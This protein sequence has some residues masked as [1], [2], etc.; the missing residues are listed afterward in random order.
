[1]VKG[2]GGKSSAIFVFVKN[3]LITTC[4]VVNA[5]TVSGPGAWLAALNEGA[6]AGFGKQCGQD[7]R[8]TLMA[9]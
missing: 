2:G 8:A 5:H 6:G 1:M 4:G 9:P 3:T 7:A